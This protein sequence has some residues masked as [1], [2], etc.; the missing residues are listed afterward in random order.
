VGLKKWFFNEFVC[1]QRSS[2]CIDDIGRLDNF[3]CFICYCS[4]V[5]VS[6]LRF[7]VWILGYGHN[8][9]MMHEDDTES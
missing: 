9:G 5:S 8:E 2:V 3:R 1:E 4:L 6:G 7:E